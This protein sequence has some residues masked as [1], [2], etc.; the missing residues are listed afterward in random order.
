ML[1]ASHRAR[2]PAEQLRTAF[3]AFVDG[4][5]DRDFKTFRA[6]ARGWLEDFALYRALKH[7]HGDVQWTRWPAALRDR[8]RARARRGAH[9]PRRRDRRTSASSSGVSP[10]TSGRSATYAHERGVALIGDI[11]IF[12]AHDCADVWQHRELF[13][14]E[15]PPASGRWWRGCRPTIS[16]RPG[17]AGATRST[18]GTGCGGRISPGGFERFAPRS[19]SFD[20]IRL[21]HF[22]GFVRYWEIPGDETTAVNGHWREGPGAA[23]FEAVSA[24]LGELPL[25]AEDLG[26][27]DP[28]VK[29]LR[30]GS[31]CPASRS[32][33]SRSGPTPNATDSC[34]TITRARAVVYTG[35]HDNDTSSAG[36]TTRAAAAAVAAQD[37]RG[38][39]GD[40][41]LPR[42]DGARRRPASARSTG[43]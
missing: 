24:A 32:C 25:I 35:S 15:R 16:A 31:G 39:A 14:L 40:A 30:D 38:A 1:A 12:M 7:T 29:A 5:G 22:I 4:G 9:R 36:S 27:R 28:E 13:T 33:S 26:R 42:A 19:A 18:A 23:F 3:A 11:P 8:D 21:D 41:A 6:E 10:E 43:G 20:A 34:P 2:A 17:S 37:R